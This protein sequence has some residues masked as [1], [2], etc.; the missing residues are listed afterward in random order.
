MIIDCHV[1]LLPRRVR[2]DRSP[3]CQSDAAFGSLFSSEKSKLVSGQE[4][5][6]YLD[7]SQ[8]DKAVVFGFPWEDHDLIKENN[9]EIWDFHERY[10]HRI[11]PFAVL[12]PKGGELLHREAERTLVNGFAGLGELAVYDGGWSFSDFEGL[13][14]SLELA[15]E[16]KAPVLIH[17]NE[18]VGHAYPGKSPVDFGGLLHMIETNPG[19]D[20]ILAHWGGGVFIY[21][22]MPEVKHV[23]A[24]TYLDTAASP[25]LYTPEIF[26][27]ACRIVGPEKIF[28][29]SDFPL[30]PLSRYLK[31]LD[32][33]GIEGPVRDG[34]LGD[35]VQ[36]LFTK[37]TDR[38]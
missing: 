27:V 25:F 1:H 2:A 29:G 7:G 9:D 22:L 16:M 17:V 15:A 4:I 18:P 12:S 3:F 8:I 19:V 23:F 28:F 34:I 31:Q 5:I 6:E 30:L 24:R 32:A 13:R 33:A 20:F 10:P 14:P 11:I 36:K 35:N 37:N 38:S 26:D 21:A